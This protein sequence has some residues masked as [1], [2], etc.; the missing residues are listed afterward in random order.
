MDDLLVP[1]IPL[2]PE[3]EEVQGNTLAPEYAVKTSDHQLE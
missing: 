2:P 3:P 1:S